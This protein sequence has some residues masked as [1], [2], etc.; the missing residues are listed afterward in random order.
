V[1]AVHEARTD[2]VF[3][4]ILKREFWPI[5]DRG[6]GIYLYDI[7]GNKYIDG[8]SGSVV[9]NIGHGVQEIA[10]A[11]YQ[12]A[13]K[14]CF[15]RPFVFANEHQIALAQRIIELS[16][17]GMLKVFFSS[18]GAE[19]VET[20]IKLARQYHVETGNANKFMV[21]SRW[22]SYH[23]NTIGALSTTG[24][25]SSREYFAP[26][27]LNFPHIPPSYC[28]RCSFGK[29]YPGC[30]IDCAYALEE[31]VK[32]QGPEYVSAFIGDPI[33][34]S[35]IEAAT[36]PPEYWPIIR[37]ICDKYKILLID[38]EVLN[39]FGR[40]GRNFGINHWDVIPDIMALGKGLSSGYAPISATVVHE[41][42]Y[43]ALR[44]GSGNFK[45][46]YTMGGN[47]LSCAAG[48]ANVKYMIRNDLIHQ[49]AKRGDY[50]FGKASTLKKL[51]IVGDIRGK[52]LLIGIEFVKDKE[53]REPFE[54]ER[55]VNGLVTRTLLKN[56]LMVM[57]GTP[58]TKYI[59]GDGILLAPPFIVTESQL[60]DIIFIL[61]KSIH[62]VQA[63]LKS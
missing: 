49:A 18:G 9:V 51:E 41:K 63:L 3:Y 14:V 15:A 38:D 55:E 8:C 42:V 5:I 2:N 1:A 19:A 54:V 7:D 43:H 36:P 29:T 6:E 22:H 25:I 57:P 61:E 62:E 17:K 45:H 35:M 53:L 52:G 47:P 26:Y 40:T 27:L 12:Q 24:R 34:G 60:D 13:K 56:G 16:P 28:Y 23:G 31:E 10:E 50:F 44:N 39:G 21:I 11:M 20:A 46:G 30:G 59:Q 58:E 37:S 33:P 4:R 32:H 48:L